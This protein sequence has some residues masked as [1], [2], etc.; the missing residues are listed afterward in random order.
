[1]RIVQFP[2]I[3]A[4]VPH[5]GLPVNDELSRTEV[6]P[7]GTSNGLVEPLECLSTQSILPIPE[8]IDLATVPE[9][10]WEVRKP[11][12]RWLLTSAVGAGMASWHLKP[13]PGEEQEGASAWSRRFRTLEYLASSLQVGIQWPVRLETVLGIRYGRLVTEQDYTRT[14]AER[15]DGTGTS[16]VIIDETGGSE[17]VTGDISYTRRTTTRSLRYNTHQILDL[18]L[19]LGFPLLRRGRLDVTGW[20]RG[21]LNAWHQVTGTRPDATWQPETIDPMRVPVNPSSRFNWGAGL[22]ARWHVTPHA[23]MLLRTGS[24]GFRYRMDREETPLFFSHRLY[25]ITLG[26]RYTP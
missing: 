6:G 23:A 5:P 15:I 12:P 19:Q 26:V 17:S 3:E 9:A 16:T 13:L 4:L 2:E 25:S 8:K 18:D 7:V 22:E 10:R 11:H 1:M 21:S 20:I 14:T 24:D